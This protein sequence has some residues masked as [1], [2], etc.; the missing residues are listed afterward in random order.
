MAHTVPSSEHLI[1]VSPILL[2]PNYSDISFSGYIYCPP[3]PKQNYYTF[4]KQINVD[5]TDISVSKFILGPL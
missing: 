2:W 5:I 3:L 4:Y 1:I